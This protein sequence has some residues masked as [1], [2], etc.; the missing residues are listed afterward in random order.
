MHQWLMSSLSTGQRLKQHNLLN[1]LKKP[2]IIS[3]FFMPEALV[4]HL[5]KPMAS[6]CEHLL[7]ALFCSDAITV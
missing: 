5:L 3:A 7:C 4:K 1:V 6:F 2:S